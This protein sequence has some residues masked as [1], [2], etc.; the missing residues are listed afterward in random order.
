MAIVAL[1]WAAGAGADPNIQDDIVHLPCIY[2]QSSPTPTITPTPTVTPTATHTVTPSPTWEC[3]SWSVNSY[4]SGPATQYDRD[5]PVRP[6]DQH[7]DKNL[8]LRGYV[9][10]DD[11]LLQRSLVSY[12]STASPR[13]PQLATLFYPARVPDLASFHRVHHWNWASSPSPGTRGD[14]I[15]QYDVTALGLATTRGEGIYCPLSDFDLGQGVAAIVIHADEDSLALRYTREDSSAPPGYTLHIDGLCT[16]PNLLTL[17]R[18]T[19]DPNGPRYEYPNG[20]YDLPTLYTGQM[21]GV[22]RGD[23]IVVALTDTGSF[24]DPRSCHEWWQYPT[25]LVTFCPAVN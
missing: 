24:M 3:P 6:A 12:G 17:Y 8:A 2:A 20:S 14:P 19:D 7:A 23:Q 11:P 15:T 21:M 18:Q 9:S 22:A 10:N 5:D 1:A 4:G 25:G 13:P 16:D